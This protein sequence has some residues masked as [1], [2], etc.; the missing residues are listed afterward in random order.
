METLEIREMISQDW[1]TDDYIKKQLLC[2]KLKYGNDFQRLFILDYNISDYDG[3]AEEKYIKDGKGNFIKIKTYLNKNTELVDLS[4][5]QCEIKFD[6]DPSKQT[7]SGQLVYFFHRK[8]NTEKLRRK[9]AIILETFSYEAF[10]NLVMYVGYDDFENYPEYKRYFTDIFKYYFLNAKSA[11][12]LK[13][14]YT[15]VPEFVLKVMAIENETVFGHLLALTKLDDTG[16]FSGWKDGSSALINVLKAFS[17]RLFLVDKFRK[18]PEL[19]NRIYFNLDGG[20]EF[21]GEMKSNRII[22][23]TILMQ[24]C[25]FAPDRPKDGAPTF[26]IGDGF[27]VNTD[28]VELSGAILGFGQ[29]DEKTFFLQQQKEVLKRTLIVPKEGDP[30]AT[31][32]A[33][34]DLDE[35]AQYSPLEMVYFIEK[36]NIEA[37]NEEIGSAVMTVPAIYVKALADAEKWEDINETIRIVADMIGIVFGVGTLALSGNPYL[38]LA[39]AADLSLAVPDLTIQ[40]FK[41]EIAKLDGGEEFL[42]QWDLIYNVVGGAVAIP[43]AGVALSQIVVSF[44]RGCLSLMKLPQTTEKINRGLRATAISVFL[45][46]NAGRFERSQLRF[47]QNTEWVIPSCGSFDA[48]SAMWLEKVGAGFIEIANETGKVS[49]QEYVFIYKGLPVAKGNKYV[50]SYADLMTKVKRASYSEEKLTEVLEEAFDDTWKYFDKEP[51]SGGKYPTKDLEKIYTEGSK[52]EFEKGVKYLSE[53]ER[54]AYEIFVQYDKIVDVKGNLVD[55]NGSTSILPN[56][57]PITT[58][59]AIFVMSKEGKL[60]LSKNYA[61]GK[62]HHSSFLSGK[63]VSAGGEIY[64]E[65]GIIKEITNDSG[66]YIP[67]LDFVK[68]NILKELEARHYFN[69]ENTKEGIKFK[70]NY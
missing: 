11:E 12:E 29:S 46:L 36:N 14:L 68:N 5:K 61:Y 22:F 65:K 69:I 30:N 63:P 54:E 38:L 57:Q 45:D 13:F 9:K 50:K 48:I 47:L 62:F 20:S 16:I 1:R 35:G 60:Y 28:V 33:T 25:L 70:S 17:D 19:C 59:K 2:D 64:I 26:M 49:K 37:D 40:A 18:N 8:A 66:H 56:G 42:R 43:Q 31:E 24:Y 41:D 10:R 21:N 51:A 27:K 23:A 44:Y 55:T 39:A 7:I 58:E 67:S 4:Q 15:S 53:K 6:I 52:K 34:E 32:L 3:I